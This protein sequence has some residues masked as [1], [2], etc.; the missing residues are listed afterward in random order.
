L[1]PK[2]DL[3]IFDEVAGANFKLEGNRDMSKGYMVEDR[4]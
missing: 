1:D 4:P 2:F 3:V